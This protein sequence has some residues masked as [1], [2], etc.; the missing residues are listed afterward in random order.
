MEYTVN[1]DRAAYKRRDVIAATGIPESSLNRW[2]SRGLM[3]G[4]TVDVPGTGHHWLFSI[5]DVARLAA[6]SA[7]IKNG[8]SVSDA[9]LVI[10]SAITGKEYWAKLIERREDHLFVC[11]RRR[12]GEQVISEVHCGFRQVQIFLTEEPDG[13]GP[14]EREIELP[15]I[16]RSIFDVGPV[17]R[18]AIKALLK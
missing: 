13:C 18:N 9:I 4:A 16:N 14:N 3:I 7:L 15:P 2:Q 10:D 8:L 17:V 11:V 12:E 6:I 5:V 1:V